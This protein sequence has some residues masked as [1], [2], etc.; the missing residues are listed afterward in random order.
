MKTILAELRLKEKS[1]I[2]SNT[3]QATGTSHSKMNKAN[4][5]VR[6]SNFK[7]RTVQFQPEDGQQ[8][9]LKGKLSLYAPR[10]NYQF[11]VE[12]MQAAGSGQLQKT[13]D[14]LKIR[15]AQQGWFDT[16]KKQALPSL[17]KQVVII[18]S[19]QGAAIRDM[20]TTF[21]RRF[22]GIRLVIIPVPVQG[23]GAAQ[24]IAEAIAKANQ[25]AK[26]SDQSKPLL[27]VGRKK[28]Y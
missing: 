27:S 19:P 7:I 28:K 10:G 8:V 21:A 15:L 11:I 23:D 20:Q 22:A 18:T 16:D 1:R 13:F 14:A 25:W 6:C 17:A 24:A 12:R 26:A 5:A 9:Q 2:Y 4:S 3:A